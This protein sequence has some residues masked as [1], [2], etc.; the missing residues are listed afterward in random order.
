MAC[1]RPQLNHFRFTHRSDINLANKAVKELIKEGVAK[2]KIILGIP[3]Y[4]RKGGEVRSYAELVDDQA[5]QHT[6]EEENDFD[7][8]HHTQL[9][10]ASFRMRDEMKGFM[11][12]SQLTAQRKTAF[13][14]SRGLGGVFVWEVGQDKL[15]P[16]VSLLQGVMEVGNGSR[17]LTQAEM[18]MGGGLGRI[19]RNF[20]TA[21][22]EDVGSRKERRRRER[23]QKEER[24]RER[25]MR[26]GGDE[27]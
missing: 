10:P 6:G 27:L 17:K 3:A 26:G 25:R 12:D 20:K 9:L 19:E 11:F 23:A 15:V 18:T 14:K 5:K 1:L 13:A 4:G 21:E 2:E 8:K 7:K 22:H 16:G 24:E